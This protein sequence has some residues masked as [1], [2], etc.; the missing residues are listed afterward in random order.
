MKS[1]G[2]VSVSAYSTEAAYKANSSES[3]SRQH[4]NALKDGF[5][6]GIDENGKYYE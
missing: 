5:I 1:E 2:W 3:Y 4:P 6:G